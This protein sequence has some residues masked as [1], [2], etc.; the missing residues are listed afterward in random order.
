MPSGIDDTDK[1]RLPRDEEFDLVKNIDFTWDALKDAGKIIV[2]RHVM[3][4]K[5][6]YIYEEFAKV[7]GKPDP[8][9]F[10]ASRWISDAEFGRQML[11]GVNPV[12]I[13]KCTSLPANFPVSEEMVKG[14]LN[15]RISL[16]E[17]M[18]VTCCHMNSVQP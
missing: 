7:L 4:L 1:K 11:N 14:L 2:K 10:D 3:S 12:V 9:V 13:R 5:H 16:S 15:R 18:K 8:A 17:E 6:L